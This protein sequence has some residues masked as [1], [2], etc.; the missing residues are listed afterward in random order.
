M[1]LKSIVA[2]CAIVGGSLLAVVAGDVDLEGVKC[3]MN[4]KAAAKEATAVDY[5]GGKVFF[6]CDNCKSAFEA[7]PE[8]FTSKA[9]YQLVKSKQAKQT[10]CPISGQPVNEEKKAK[11]GEMEVALCC[12]NCQAKVEGAEADE[13]LELVF[14][15]EAFKKGFEM[16]KEDKQDK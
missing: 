16:K 6:C 12:G 5:N 10:K 13:K 3:L 7:E 4:P 2:A 14:S 15:K 11:V 9:N 8:K 1:V